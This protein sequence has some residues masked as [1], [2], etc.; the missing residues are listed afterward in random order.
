[1]CVSLSA[2]RGGWS[3]L[4]DPK[5]HRILQVEGQLFGG[6]KGGE[7]FDGSHHFL[8]A[9]H[10]YRVGHHQSIDHGHVSTLKQEGG[11]ST[12]QFV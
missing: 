8:N 11:K 5:D 10:L 1:M 12:I 6:S 9:D 2:Y 7:A 4:V 3:N